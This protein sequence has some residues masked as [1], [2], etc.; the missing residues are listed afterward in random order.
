MINLSWPNGNT[1][2]PKYDILH[3]MTKKPVKVPDRGWRW[4]EETF[5]SMLDYN[6]VKIRYD[7]SIICG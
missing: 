2:G 3:P 6:N 7:G 1:F 4:S 5:K